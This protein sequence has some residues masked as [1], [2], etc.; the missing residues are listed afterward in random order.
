MNSF[1]VTSIGSALPAMGTQ[2]RVW[3]ESEVEA[4]NVRRS[5]EV[6][7][8]QRLARFNDLCPAQF[9]E[10]IRRE[11]LPNLTA[12]DAADAWTG[13]HPG[14]WLWSAATGLGKTRMLWR[15]LGRMHVEHG[16][17]ILKLSG[18][19]MAEEYFRL[20][21]D[22]KPGD[23]YRWLEQS[24]LIFL[25]DLDKIDF[26]NPRSPRMLRETFDK[27]YEAKKP[28]LVTANEP[29]AWF[30]STLGETSSPAHA[31]GVS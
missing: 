19:A 30:G 17:S 7:R 31:R 3:T 22:G 27:F 13:G 2:E 25:D 14:I 5:S 11:L 16:R 28:V 15:H 6:L 8:E 4:Y 26:S 9:R 23:F 20:H 12:W 24:D 1:E 10:R 18:Q 29:I 21:M